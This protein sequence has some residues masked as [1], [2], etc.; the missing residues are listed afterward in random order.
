MS[1]YRNFVEDFPSR[2]I[3]LLDFTAQ[4]EK[5][6]LEVTLLLAVAGQ[7]IIMPVERLDINSPDSRS[8]ATHPSGDATVFKSAKSKL[9]KVLDKECKTS[10]LFH[11]EHGRFDPAAWEYKECDADEVN[12]DSVED[13]KPIDNKKC[14]TILKILRRALAHGNL[15]TDGKDPINRLVF[16]SEIREKGRPIKYE[17]LECDPDTL[18]RFLKAWANE[19]KKLDLNPEQV[20]ESPTWWQEGVYE[21]VLPVLRHGY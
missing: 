10:R 1:N 15:R 3:D 21:S 2:C 4:A 14:R 9:D 8:E 20:I 5:K 13:L 18:R 6:D 16:F 19:L 12:A 17:R 7:A 11:G